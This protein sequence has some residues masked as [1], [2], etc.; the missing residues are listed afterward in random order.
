M[1]NMMVRKKSREAR[2]P[3]WRI[4]KELGV[5]E[6]TMTRRLRMELPIPEQKMLCSLIE[7]I[8]VTQG[9]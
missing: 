3:I 8:E 6:A 1:R 9:E 4:A 2:I 5:S 7:R